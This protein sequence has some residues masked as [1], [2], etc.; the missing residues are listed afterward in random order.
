[1]TDVIVAFLDMETLVMD[2]QN[3]NVILLVH[4]VLYVMK[5]VDNVFA[6]EEYME[7]DVIYVFLLITILDQKDAN[8]AIVMN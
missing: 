2:V 6:R 5:L 8:F 3:V 4:W 1:M 7:N